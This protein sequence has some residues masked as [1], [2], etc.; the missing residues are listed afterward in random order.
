MEL[1]ID[2]LQVNVDSLRLLPLLDDD[3][4]DFVAHPLPKFGHKDFHI[5][6]LKVIN[7]ALHD[8]LQLYEC[9]RQRSGY[10]LFAFQDIFHFGVKSFLSVIAGLAMPAIFCLPIRKPQEL[11]VRW[12][13][14]LCFGRA[15]LNA[16][17]PFQPRSYRLHHSVGCCFTFDTDDAVICVSGK[18]Q[19]SGFKFLVEF[20]QIDIC[21]QWGNRGSLC[22][23]RYYAELILFGIQFMRHISFLTL[24]NAI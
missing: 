8:L 5:S 24:R 21:Q 13:D 20:I 12:S 9:H 6:Y 2:P 4:S 18:V 22:R 3:H 19:T 1:A 17:F 7:P 14:Y 23:A 10:C 11:A 16:Q 15:D